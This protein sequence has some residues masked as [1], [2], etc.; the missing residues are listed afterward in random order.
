MYLSEAVNDV[1]R[2]KSTKDPDFWGVYGDEYQKKEASSRLDKWWNREQKNLPREL[3][4]S[5]K[6]ERVFKS[7]DTALEKINDDGEKDTDGEMVS[8]S[9]AHIWVNSDSVYLLLANHYEVSP[10]RIRDIFFEV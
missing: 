9:P 1:N 10:Q 4:T 5:R 3:P 7:F 2:N 8:V 6:I